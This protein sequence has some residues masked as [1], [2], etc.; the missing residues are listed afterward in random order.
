MFDVVKNV[1]RL[2]VLPSNLSHL[3]QNCHQHLH[4]LD[5]MIQI[6]F[7]QCEDKG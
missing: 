5:D 3:L 7:R 1:F 4:F 2:F 6:K